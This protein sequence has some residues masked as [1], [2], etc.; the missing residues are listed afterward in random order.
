ME[1][2]TYELDPPFKLLYEDEESQVL[3]QIKTADLGD[4]VDKCI[5]FLEACGYER[6]D[7]LEEMRRP[8]YGQPLQE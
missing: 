2:I 1:N 5:H 3:I 7:I 8:L 4:V 6:E